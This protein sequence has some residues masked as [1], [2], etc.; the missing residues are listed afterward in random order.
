MVNYQTDTL[1]RGG[2]G[3]TIRLAPGGVGVARTLAFLSTASSDSFVRIER[4][5]D[6][7]AEEL[8]DSLLDSRDSEVI[9]Q[10]LIQIA[11]S[12][13]QV[14]CSGEDLTEQINTEL[15]C[16]AAGEGVNRETTQSTTGFFRAL[17]DVSFSLVSSIPVICSTLLISVNF[18]VQHCGGDRETRQLSV[19][20]QGSFQ[21][22][23]LTS[24][25]LLRGE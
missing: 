20:L 10:R 25:N 16:K 1:G 2:G 14:K 9:Y 23:T 17:S 13:V 18:K 22:D 12:E 19:C 3:G 4:G 6:V 21:K 11:P 8:G 7:F 5:A 24:V 15:G